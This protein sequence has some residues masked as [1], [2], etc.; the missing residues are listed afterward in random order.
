MKSIKVGNSSYHQEYICR[1]FG[2]GLYEL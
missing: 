1:A 2:E